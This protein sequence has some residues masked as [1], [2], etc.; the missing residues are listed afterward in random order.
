MAR[1]AY[2]DVNFWFVVCSHRSVLNLP[3]HQHPVDDS[4]EHDVFA[5]E[6]ITL[7]C[8]DKELATI[9]ILGKFSLLL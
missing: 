6:I 4:A 1:L 7:G 3:D 2:D 8:G 5:I 9:G